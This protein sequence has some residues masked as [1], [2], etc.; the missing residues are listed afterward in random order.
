MSRS[1]KRWPTCFQTLIQI[2][3][4]PI[5][6]PKFDCNQ[7]Y[8]WPTFFSN[9]DVAKRQTL[10]NLFSNFDCNQTLANIFPEI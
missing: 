2:K 5:F 6:F 3:R 7:T 10:A 8:C 9:F 4:W 1:A